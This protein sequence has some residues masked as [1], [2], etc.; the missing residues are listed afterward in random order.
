M[1]TAMLSK[2]IEKALN[3]QIALEAY[4][5]NSYLA[6]ASW[7]ETQGFRGATKFFYAQS[8]EERVHMLKLVKY[9]NASGG[10]A[11]I[12]SIKEAAETYN[13]LQAVFEVSLKQ[14]QSVTASINKLV[15]L[16]FNAKDY[17]AHHFL[18][19]YVEEQH[20]EENLFRSILDLF[21]IAGK[22]ERSLII[23]DNEIV[24]IREEVEAA[25]K[26]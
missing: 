1:E 14:E 17:A 26:D 24:K 5:S 16:T 11:I 10:H 9:V 7:C 25:N 19:W 13:S 15:E 2:K 20:E 18:Q 3:E 8:D 21:K 6:M 23:L 22:D 12:P 4:A